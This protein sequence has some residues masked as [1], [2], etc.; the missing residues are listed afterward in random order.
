MECPKC[1]ASIRGDYNDHGDPL[2]IWDTPPAFCHNCGHGF[3]WTE[4]KIAAAVDLVKT[5]GKL[6]LAE[7]D[8]FQSDLTEMVKDSPNTQ[9]ASVRFKKI[10]GKV[11]T[12]GANGVRDIVVDVLSEAVKKAI[13]GR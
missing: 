12:T 3:P 8:Q 2:V 4:R 7:V 5:G 10:M 11:G 1:G 6:S 9:A 13:W